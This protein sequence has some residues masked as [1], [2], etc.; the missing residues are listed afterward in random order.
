MPQMSDK[1]ADGSTPSLSHIVLSNRFQLVEKLSQGQFAQVFLAKDFQGDEHGTVIVKMSRKVEMTMM[2][3][4]ILQELSRMGDGDNFYAPR[5]FGG[6]QFTAQR[7][8]QAKCSGSLEIKT[9]KFSFIAMK[10]LG[11]TLRQH[12]LDQN[13]NLTLNEI[14]HIGI[15]LLTQFER[16]HTLGKVYNDLN[17]DNILVGDQ[18]GSAESLHKYTLIDYGLCSDF[19]DRRKQH[20]D[21]VFQGQFRG[22]MVLASADALGLWTTSRKD[23]LIQLVH[24]MVYLAQGHLSQFT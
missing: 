10:Q 9:H 4:D 1:T 11:K 21:Q 2:E 13:Q 17:L 20:Y 18:H 7:V 16:L 8:R 3:L 15:A 5:I 24:L 14:C 23:D 19:T 6:G 12:F 22:N